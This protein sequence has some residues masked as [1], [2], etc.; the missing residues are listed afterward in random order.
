MVGLA[1]PDGGKCLILKISHGVLGI[2][3]ETTGYDFTI[4]GDDAGVPE[5]PAV[6][7]KFVFDLVATIGLAYVAGV[8][9]NTWDEWVALLIVINLR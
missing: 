4:P 2:L 1:L 3:I 9:L 8:S 7:L 6:V 5:L